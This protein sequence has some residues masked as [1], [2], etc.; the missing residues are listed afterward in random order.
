MA[1][2]KPTKSNNTTAVDKSEDSMTP[3]E[4]E[5]K[6]ATDDAKA[7][8]DRQNRVEELIKY[9]KHFLSIK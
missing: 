1:D 8:Q 4:L 9:K 3:Q 5:A 7:E 2:V 6:K